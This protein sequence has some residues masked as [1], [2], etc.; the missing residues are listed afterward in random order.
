[1]N[2]V[3]R[4][5]NQPINDALIDELTELL[6]EAASRSS[7][8]HEDIRS[9]VG[10]FLEAYVDADTVLCSVC[11]ETKAFY[12]RQQWQR[13]WLRVVRQIQQQGPGDQQFSG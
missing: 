5:A 4:L 9:I 10:D 11:T 7:N 3:D 8:P 12:V 2:K 1:M 13:V 6:Y